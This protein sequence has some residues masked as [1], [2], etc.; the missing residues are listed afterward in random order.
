MNDLTPE[1]PNKFAAYRARKKAVGLR[2]VRFWGPDLRDPDVLA[3]LKREGDILRN[4]PEE[5]E[6]ADFIEKIMDDTMRDHPY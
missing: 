5:R 3:Q 2:E 6:A 4:A 1:R